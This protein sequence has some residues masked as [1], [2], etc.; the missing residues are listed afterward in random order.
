MRSALAPL[1]CLALLAGCSSGGGGAPLPNPFAPWQYA[2]QAPKARG[3]ACEGDFD[4]AVGDHCHATSK[5][6]SAPVGAGAPC[7]SLRA[8]SAGLGCRMNP[9]RG[10]CFQLTCDAQGN[11]C[12]KGAA[13]GADC[14]SAPCP[15]NQL[16][17]INTPPGGTCETLPTAGQD[18]SQYFIGTDCAGPSICILGQ[19]V[20]GAGG[21]LGERCPMPPG[22]CNAGLTC[23]SALDGT[24]T[25]S[26]PR[27]AGQACA[28][29][30]ECAPGT[31][32]DLSRLVCT[33][34][35]AIGERCQN[36]NEC[37][38]APFDLERGV[39]CIKRTCVDTSKAGADCWPNV[40]SQCTN[41]RVCRKK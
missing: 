8:C 6:C 5:T 16:C 30:G 4:C 34:N 37:G 2:C 40:P 19:G 38:E 31:H 7:D 23:L 17:E 15:S 39:D 14:S 36:G 20:C 28:S 35:A 21:G 11:N 29:G 9:T 26:T 41:G 18:C 10:Q 33:P 25:C 13:T 3:Q 27:Q 12:V 22:R 1:T 24:T 32:C